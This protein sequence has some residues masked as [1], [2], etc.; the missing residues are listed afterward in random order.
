[1]PISQT[2]ITGSFKTAGGADAALT[3]ATFTL[4]ASDFEAGECITAGTVTAAVVTAAGDFTVSLWPNSVGMIGT[5]RY[6]LALTFSDGSRVT[7]PTELYVKASTTM[8]TLEGIAFETRAMDAVRPAAL[9]IV[10]Q[11]QYDAINPKSPNT[12][13]LVRG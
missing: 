12:V 9:V 11:A 8:Q 2:T 6:R 4:T 10:T 5:S 7:W 1:M 13:Y 3:A